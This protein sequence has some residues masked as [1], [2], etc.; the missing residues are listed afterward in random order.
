ME[1]I[2]LERMQTATTA[3]AAL[4]A[5]AELCDYKEERGGRPLISVFQKP[6][7]GSRLI[8]PTLSICSSSSARPATSIVAS[9]SIHPY[10]TLGQQPIPVSPL[11]NNVLPNQQ[12]EQNIVREILSAS[13]SLAELSKSPVVFQG[14]SNLVE[15]VPSDSTTTS[16]SSKRVNSLPSIQVRDFFI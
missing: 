9:P 1:S 6:I 4:A 5:L 2:A 12:R 11:G 7:V 13:L 16:A 3:G 8:F 14:E 15:N 10:G